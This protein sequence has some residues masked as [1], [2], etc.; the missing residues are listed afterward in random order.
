[1][2]NRLRHFRFRLQLQLLNV[3]LGHT[4]LPMNFIYLSS[5]YNLA[6]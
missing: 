4:Y 6:M 1:M 5:Q 3:N 2:N